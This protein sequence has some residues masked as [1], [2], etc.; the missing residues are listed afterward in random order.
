M[1]EPA[2]S[3]QGLSRHFADVKAVEKLHFDIQAGEMFG[4][5]G[6]DGAGKTTTIRLLC[7]ILTPTEGT[8]TIL[9]LDL[10]RDIEKIKPQIGYLS[11]RFS[12]YP[13]LTVDENIEFFAEIH[14]VGDYKLRRD[15]LLDFTRLTQ[16]RGRLANQLSGG[17]K[18][19]L[20]LACTLV[21]K[22]KI[23]YLDEP[24]TGVDPVSRRDFWKILSSLLSEGITI[25]MTT[26]YLDEAERCSH[27]GLMNGGVLLEMDTP[28]VVKD[29]MVGSVLEIVT[30]DVH[31]AH[32]L[33]TTDKSLLGVQAFGDRLNVVI[34][35][36]KA[37]AERIVSQL[38]ANKIEITQTRI[39]PT[40]LENVF[41]SL[42]SKSD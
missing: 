9:G 14:E 20:A 39:I 6:P 37:D 7:G 36:A 25:V 17:M 28:Q 13:D 29:R 34:R 40:S 32:T 1:P 23:I 8:A 11:Q 31:A 15:E 35:D 22:P 19:K 26:P 10:I 4:L 5:V 42:M 27:V 18:Q 21:H 33:L 16:F 12:L 2:I 41:I 30:P 24:T 3:I 38:K